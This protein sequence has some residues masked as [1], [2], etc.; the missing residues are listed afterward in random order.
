[1]KNEGRK[2]RPLGA[3][4][5]GPRGV[6]RVCFLSPAEHAEVLRE[7]AIDEAI[8]SMHGE[9]RG[10]RSRAYFAAHPND[11]SLTGLD[12]SVDLRTWNQKPVEPRISAESFSDARKTAGITQAQAAKRIGCA[13]TTVVAIEQCIRVV[14][15][16][17]FAALKGEPCKEST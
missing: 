4:T 14:R 7:I 11:P 13:R 2:G 8:E 1:M 9:T 3:Y 16:A 10:E 15:A 5:K 12:L 6:A 17:E